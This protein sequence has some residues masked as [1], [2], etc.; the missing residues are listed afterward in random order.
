MQTQTYQTLVTWKLLNVSYMMKT[1][2]CFLN[3]MY[4]GDLAVPNKRISFLVGECL[5]VSLEDISM[6]IFLVY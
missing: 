4:E 3:M 6:L 1:V 2:H 5:N